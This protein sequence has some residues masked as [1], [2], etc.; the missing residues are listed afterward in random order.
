M[1]KLGE[2]S[3]GKGLKKLKNGKKSCKKVERNGKT[4]GKKLEK[5]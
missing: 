1:E 4:M 3:G 2:N 5:R